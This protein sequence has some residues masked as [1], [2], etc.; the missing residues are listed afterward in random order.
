MAVK[1]HRCSLTWLKTGGHACWR[2]EKALQDKGVDYEVVKEPGL[3]KSRRK[4]VLANT[5]QTALPVLE[6]EDGR[7]IREQSKD[8]AAKIESGEL[9]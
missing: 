4:E 5:G 8:L 1:L 7:W 6:L 2:V 3:P 9:P